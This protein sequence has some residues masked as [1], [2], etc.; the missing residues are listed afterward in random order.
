MKF[1]HLADLHL[2]KI[3]YSRNLIDIQIDLL[4]QVTAYMNDKQIDV[5]V[6]AGDIYDRAVAS[7]ESV[8]ALNEFLDLLINRYHKKVLMISGNH[9]SNERLNF[10][11]SLLKSKGLY[12]VSFVQKEMKPIEIDGV[13]FYL[14]PFFKPSY[15]RY[16][17]DQDD[18]KT[19]QEAFAY[20]LSQQ[21]IDH[22][23][24]NVLVTHQFIAGNKEVIRSESEVI[25]TVGGSEIID[26][27]LVKDFDYVAL[28]H[29]HASQKIKYDHVRYA[30]SLMKYSFDEVNQQKGMTEVTIENGQ[31]SVK[32]IPLQ[33][34]KDL[35][36]LKGTFQQIMDY[37]D[38]KKDFISIELLDRQIIG[39]AFERLKEKYP[40]LLQITY[41]SLD[42]LSSAKQTTASLHFEKQTPLELFCEFYE[43]MKGVSPANEDIDLIAQ[44]LKEDDD[45]DAA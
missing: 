38:N 26:V 21:K 10:A 11:S 34:L 43:K 13:R 20:Y 39:H 23:Q 33:P 2:G 9:D 25:L 14:L 40:E 4:H 24:P 44:F 18:L 17:F 32:V 27:D 45:H 3:I 22:C 16:L 6:I 5:L 7:Q 35:I 30:G 28:G 1:I 8:A 37:P 41:A 15:I 31:V 36:R 42:D 29:I 19:Y 12:I